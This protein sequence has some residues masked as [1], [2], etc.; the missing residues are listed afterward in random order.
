MT[1]RRFSLNGRINHLVLRLHHATHSRFVTLGHGSAR[2]ALG[3]GA[4][5]F[6]VM[7]DQHQPGGIGIESVDQVAGALELKFR[8]AEQAAMVAPL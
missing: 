5:G 6:R 1:D 2:K 3:K 8:K 4:C 7:G